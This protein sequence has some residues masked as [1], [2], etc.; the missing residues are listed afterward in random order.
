MGAAVQGAPVQSFADIQNW[1][2]TGTNSAVLVI[3]WNDSKSPESLAWGYRWNGAATGEQMF[4]AIAESD[5]RLYAKIGTPGTYGTPIYGVGY[6]LDNDS[7]FGVNDGTTFNAAGFA[8]VTD[9]DADGGGA[10]DT[11]DHYREGWFN[12]GFWFHYTNDAN[13]YAV[14]SSWG[15]GFGLFSRTLVNGGWDSL[16]YAPG[17]V[18]SAPGSAEPVPVPEPIG[19][20]GMTVFGAIATLRR[21]RAA[22]GQQ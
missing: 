20:A 6:D 1:V 2:G 13:P 22:R 8:T 5:P 17:F 21:Q 7:N 19:F 3:D 10:S 16:S 4:L 12:D 15:D 9:N 11:D 18:G 14:G